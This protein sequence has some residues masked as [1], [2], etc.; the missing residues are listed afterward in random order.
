MEGVWFGFGLVLCLYTY[1]WM[2]MDG[3]MDGWIDR[4][5]DMDR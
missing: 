5:I 4:W 3:L 1:G 2:G